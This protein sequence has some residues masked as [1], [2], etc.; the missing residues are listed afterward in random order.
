MKMI[1]VSMADRVGLPVARTER[2]YR[3]E[4]EC[5]DAVE[6]L[7]RILAHHDL[8]TRRVIRIEVEDY[9]EFA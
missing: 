4:V 9:N 5:D 7:R 3:K 6:L 1:K 2:P 8:G